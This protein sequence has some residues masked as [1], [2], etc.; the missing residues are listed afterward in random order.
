MNENYL[1]VDQLGFKFFIFSIWWIKHHSEIR[2][3]L[4]LYESLYDF[5]FSYFHLVKFCL[6][7]HSYFLS[8]TTKRTI[9][10]LFVRGDGVILVSPPMRTATWDDF[11]VF[12]IMFDILRHLFSH[13]FLKDCLHHLH[14][15]CLI[16]VIH[17]SI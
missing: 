7:C 14:Y 1:I 2:E 3:L 10:M 12:S 4:F 6:L 13:I 15:F 9:A 17:L 8:Q 16:C 11:I 5:F